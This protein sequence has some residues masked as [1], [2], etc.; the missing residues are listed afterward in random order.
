MVSERLQGE[1]QSLKVLSLEI[2]HSHTKMNVKSA[3]Q[4]LEF[5]MVRAVSKSHTLD[6]SCK[7]PCAFTHS[8]A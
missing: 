4:K 3:P 7:F 1:E 5:A 6:C 2:P 8:Y